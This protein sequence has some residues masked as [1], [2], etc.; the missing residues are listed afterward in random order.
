MS[1]TKI[2]A[3]I[4]IPF[5]GL[6]DKAIDYNFASAASAVS[7]KIIELFNENDE[8]YDELEVHY[9]NNHINYQRPH[10]PCDPAADIDSYRLMCL[11]SGIANIMC[12]CDVVVF[13]NNWHDARGCMMEMLLALMYHKP[14]VALDEQGNIIDRDHMMDIV[15]DSINDMLNNV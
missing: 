11:G 15:K 1:K 4:C 14:I 9:F 10:S 12:E 3:M 7:N 6:T 13:A 5:S 2:N 8:G